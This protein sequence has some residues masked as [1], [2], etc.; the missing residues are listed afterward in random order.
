MAHTLYRRIALV[1]SPLVLLAGCASDQALENFRSQ[2]QDQVG[3]RVT[4]PNA[5]RNRYPEMKMATRQL[6]SGDLEETLKLGRGDRCLVHFIIDAS[7]STIGA[8]RY[9]GTNHDC[10]NLP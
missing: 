3:L 9:E 7:S 8:W 1:S 5:L 2:I 4:D 6:D 10:A